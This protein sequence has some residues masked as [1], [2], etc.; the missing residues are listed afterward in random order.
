MPLTTCK[1]CVFYNAKREAF[2]S[3]DGKTFGACMRHP[4]S[5]FAALA[6]QPA[7]NDEAQAWGSGYPFVEP[8]DGCGDGEE[9]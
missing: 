4:P 9:R 2:D 1:K 6:S 5:C 7:T 8:N 3:Y